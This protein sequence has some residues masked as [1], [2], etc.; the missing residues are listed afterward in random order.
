MPKPRRRVCCARSAMRPTTSASC[1]GCAAMGARAFRSSRRSCCRWL[2]HAGL[3]RSTWLRR[4]VHRL[5]VGGGRI[6]GSTRR[7]SKRQHQA[8]WAWFELESSQ[9][10][11]ADLDAFRLLAV[12]LAHWDNKS[13]NQR[14]VCL[15][16]SRR[17]RPESARAPLLM[18]Q[19]L[20]ATF[21]PDQGEHRRMERAAGIWADRRTCPYR[22]GRSRTRAPTFPDARISE[23]GRV[24]LAQDGSAHIAGSRSDGCSATRGFPRF[25]SATDDE[26]RPG[27]VDGGVPAP[28][29]SD[30]QRRPALTFLIVISNRRLAGHST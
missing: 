22:C 8:G 19:D 25:Y 20:G 16:E 26:Q 7:R 14:L 18:M 29:R 28:G 10:P 5:R 30:R 11:R 23:A 15:D 3:L 2:A 1:R 12:F 13:E 27:G 21:G 6:A 9:A 17:L 24:Q 4:R